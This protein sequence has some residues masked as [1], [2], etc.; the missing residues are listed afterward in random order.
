M[1]YQPEKEKTTKEPTKKICREVRIT[2][3]SQVFPFVFKI[4]WP[5][6]IEKIYE[7]EQTSSK[8]KRNPKA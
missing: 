2:P 8:R 5:F 3:V 1:K 4:N 7:K 6:N